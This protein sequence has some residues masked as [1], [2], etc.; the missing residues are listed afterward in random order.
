ML[1]GADGIYSTVR[2]TIFG[3]ETPTYSGDIAWRALVSAAGLPDAIVRPVVKIWWG[4]GK[5]FV[6]YPVRDGTLVNCVGVVARRDEPQPGSRIEPGDSEEFRNDFAGWHRDV[7]ALIDGTARDGCNKWALFDRPPMPRWSDHRITLLGDACHA[8]LPFM[9]QGAAMAMEDAAVLARCIADG[10]DDPRSLERY[11]SLRRDRTAQ[12]QRRARLNARIFHLSGPVAWMRNQTAR[13]IQDRIFTRP[14]RLQRA[15]PG[16]ELRPRRRTARMPHSRRFQPRLW[17][18]P[19][20]RPRNKRSQS[21]T[22]PETLDPWKCRLKG[23]DPGGAA[24]VRQRA[25]AEVKDGMPEGLTNFR[26]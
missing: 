4:P 6:H 10:G 25:W 24:W 20:R 26:L 9:A 19:T 2:T 22:L 17:P 3:S 15:R 8:A 5:H 14:I 18:G 23:R 7:Q 1:V 16:R 11:E 13:L 21:L 12:V